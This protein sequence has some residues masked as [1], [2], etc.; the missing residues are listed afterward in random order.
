MPDQPVE[1]SGP[2]AYPSGLEA[3]VSRLEDNFDAMK[4]DMTEIRVS[5]A[6]LEAKFDAIIPQL[7][8]K[9]QVAQLPTR[10]Y[11]WGVLGVLIACIYGGFG[12]ALAA[13]TVL[14]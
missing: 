5:I 1:P 4:T 7:A 14:R 2:Q 9:E 10:T 11:L 12:A 13:Y 6:R 8:T 3:R